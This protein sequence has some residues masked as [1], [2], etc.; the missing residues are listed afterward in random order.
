MGPSGRPGNAG[1]DVS[2]IINVSVSVFLNVQLSMSPI[3]QSLFSADVGDENPKV[4][5]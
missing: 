2:E 4:S 5:S 3:C 1:T